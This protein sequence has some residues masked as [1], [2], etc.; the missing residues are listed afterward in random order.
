MW[1]RTVTGLL[2]PQP[3]LRPLPQVLFLRLHKI[4]LRKNDAPMRFV[5][6]LAAD[7]SPEAALLILAARVGSDF[8]DSRTTALIDLNIDWDYLLKAARDHGVIP[9]LYQHLEA[10]FREAVPPEVFEQ[11]RDQALNNLRSNLALTRELFNLLELFAA[12]DIHAIPYKGPALAASAYGD[13]ALRQFVDLDLIVHKKDV[14]RARQLLVARGWRPEFELTAAQE[15]AF[16]DHYY[17]YGFFNEDRVLVEIHWGLAEGF[18]SFPIDAERLWERLVPITIAGRPLMTLSPEDSLVIVCVHSSKHLWSRLGWISD[19]AR[20]IES[21]RQMNWPLVMEHAATLGSKRMLKLGL[22]LARELLGAPLPDEVSRELH[23]DSSVKALAAEVTKRLFEER[24]GAPG[25]V[26]T[27]VLHLKMRERL[28]DR[29]RY[30][31]RF[32]FRTTVGDFTSV[33][34]PRALFFLYYPLRPVRLAAKY[35]RRLLAHVLPRGG[36]R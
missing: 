21:N 16:L 31:L 36:E 18:F 25:I 20:L 2:P 7:V 34:L 13:I 11:L 26:E 35:G 24:T 23:S 12:H 33:P 15:A 5:S 10:G 17:D 3:R 32:A 14:L 27:S 8:E 22:L 29:T 1:S 28:R 19:V 4:A 6:G 30:C 9:L